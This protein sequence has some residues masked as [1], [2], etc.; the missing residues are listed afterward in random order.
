MIV[1]VSGADPLNRFVTAQRP[2][3]ATVVEELRRGSKASHW[4][5]FVFPQIAGLGRSEM[6]RRYAITSLDEAR[7]YLVHPILGS[8]LLEC[9]RLVLAVSGR[10]A[11]DIFGPIDARSAL[12]RALSP[13]R[14]RSPCSGSLV[15]LRRRSDPMT[16]A[17]ALAVKPGLDF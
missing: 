10:T 9:A 7:A 4:M 12:V 16:W 2:V 11:V 5:W 15:V 8:R 1:D 6:A 3:Y 13:A 14:R 17:A